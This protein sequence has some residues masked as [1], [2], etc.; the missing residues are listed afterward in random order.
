MLDSK[1]ENRAAIAEAG[2]KD[3]HTHSCVGGSQWETC[4]GIA[5]EKQYGDLMHRDIELIGQV[6]YMYV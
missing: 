4:G 6:M 2:R 5:S 1:S 3:R